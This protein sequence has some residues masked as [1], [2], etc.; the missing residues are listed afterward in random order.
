MS[1]LLQDLHYACPQEEPGFAIAAILILGSGIGA[2]VAIFSV[3]D[4]VLLKPMPYANPDRLVSFT[5]SLSADEFGISQGQFITIEKQSR[6]IESIGAF[7]SFELTLSRL[8]SRH[9]A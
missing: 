9:L 2:A 3:A 1:S 4:G 5:T 6:T 8:A 7:F